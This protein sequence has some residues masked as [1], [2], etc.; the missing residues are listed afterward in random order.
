MCALVCVCK[1]MLVC[2]S[3][4]VRALFVCVT[5]CTDSIVTIVKLLQSYLIHHY[6]CVAL[7]HAWERMQHTQSGCSSGR[8]N[9]DV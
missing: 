7:W 5:M 1:D 9:L 6:H 4:C 8:L 2:V 3:V